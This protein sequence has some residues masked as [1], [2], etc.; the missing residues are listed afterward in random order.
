[1]GAEVGIRSVPE[2]PEGETIATRPLVQGW[3]R[4]G[5]GSELRSQ[6]TRTG[7]ELPLLLSLWLV[8][9]AAHVPCRINSY[10]L[11]KKIHVPCKHSNNIKYTY[12]E[13]SVLH[14]Y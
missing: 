7:L 8:R 10:F 2:T 13:H 5:G 12:K 14:R 3:L 6:P 1:M 11:V 4:L 9:E